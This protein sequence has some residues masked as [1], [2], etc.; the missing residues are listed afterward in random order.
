MSWDIYLKPSHGSAEAFVG[1]LR[2]TLRR[3]EPFTRTSETSFDYLSEDTGVYFGIDM[4]R[5]GDDDGLAVMTVNFA[6]PSPFGRE[7][8][9][10]LS[11]IARSL[12][13]LVR[14][15]QDDDTWRPFDETRMAESYRTSNIRAT[16]SLKRHMDGD[17][18]AHALGYPIPQAL[19][20][21]AWDWNFRRAERDRQRQREKRNL[22]IP[23][24]EFVEIG[25]RVYSFVFWFDGVATLFPKTELVGLSRNK[26]QLRT[27]GLFGRKRPSLDFVLRS[28]ID[29]ILYETYQ[30]DTMV[31]GGLSP[32]VDGGVAGQ[33]LFLARTL[34]QD[35]VTDTTFLD[36]DDYKRR[37]VKPFHRRS[38]DSLID[39]EALQP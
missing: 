22:W 39:S 21:Y 29:P 12:P 3:F 16:Q 8:A 26:Y 30:S 6:R 23:K 35:A 32:I 27:P 28:A 2:H 34:G 19:L 38:F 7:A 1:G 9:A 37:D 5:E 10:I 20:E 24:Y 13:L 4:I 25:G 36:S 18:H 14:D 17:G 31:P 33:D 11:D 15:P